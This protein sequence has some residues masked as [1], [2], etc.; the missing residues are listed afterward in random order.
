M[1]MRCCILNT[2]GIKENTV[3]RL[4]RGYIIELAA[5]SGWSQ[6]EL[7]RRMKLPKGTLSNALSG[8]RG[9]GRKVI[10]GLLRVFPQESFTD[11][12][13]SVRQVERHACNL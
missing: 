8:R 3:Y 13:L 10:A 12:V 9:A 11:M 4:N 6:N 1:E 2:Q 7:A 5:N